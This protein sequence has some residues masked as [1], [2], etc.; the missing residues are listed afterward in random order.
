[1]RSPK[2]PSP[3]GASMTEYLSFE[4]VPS[5]LR[6][7]SPAQLAAKPRERRQR[8]LARFA[9]LTWVSFMTAV[10]S[11]A[12]ARYIEATLPALGSEHMITYGIPAAKRAVAPAQVDALALEC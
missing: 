8:I 6:V 12:T 3:V 11:N 10:L 7:P 1:M 5:R 2:I 4:A 9:L